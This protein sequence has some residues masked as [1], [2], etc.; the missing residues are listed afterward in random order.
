MG[1]LE[2]IPAPRGFSNVSW[3]EIDISQVSNPESALTFGALIYSKT[4]P[5]LDIQTFAG[6]DT[7]VSIFGEPTDTD[8]NAWFQVYKAFDYKDGEVGGTAKVVRVVGDGSLNGALAVTSSSLVNATDLTTQRI[9]NEQQALDATIVFDT[10]TVANGGDDTETKIKFFTK[11]PTLIKYKVALATVADF[12]TADIVTGVS[13]A[14]NFDDVPSGTEVAIAVLDEDDKILEKFVCDLTEGNVDGFG[15]DTYI[16]HKIAKESLYILAYHNTDVVELPVSFEATEFAKNALVA[17]AKADYLNG[18]E[19][20]EDSDYVDVNYMIGHS[21][22]IDEMITLCENRKDVS[23]RWSPLPSMLIGKTITD[24]VDDL[25]TYTTSTLNRNTTYA[26]FYANCGLFYDKFNKKSRWISL[27]GDI[28][29]LRILRNLQANPWF[30]AAGPNQQF[31]NIIKLAINPKPA[32]QIILNKSKANSVISKANVGK[33]IAWTNNYTSVKSMLQLET[34]RE[35]NIYIWR[36]N[37]MFLFYKLFEQ[38]DGITRA[39]IRAQMEKFMGSVEAGRGIESNWRVICD[40][41]NN[42]STIINQQRLVCTIVYT[43]IGHVREIVL[44]AIISA[45]GQDVE[46]IL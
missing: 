46:E 39:L 36:A 3:N 5:V 10:H 23:M 14:N 7:Y 29:G 15:E 8:Y 4:G 11:Y 38:N 1:L 24:A 25:V 41:S 22:V 31:K 37:R 20:F 27:S 40:E 44:N 21:E 42:T 33:M 35:L 32:Y 34:T 16:N 30:A 18:L 12:A 19:L 2:S 9:D 26:S 17:P 45:S 13:F 43:P 6:Q 28:V